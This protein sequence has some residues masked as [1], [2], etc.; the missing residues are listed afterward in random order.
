MT[1]PITFDL[2]GVI[3]I[4]IHVWNTTPPAIPVSPHRATPSRT[5][6]TAPTSRSPRS[7]LSLG[8]GCPLGKNCSLNVF[9]S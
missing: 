9:P 1:T 3:S 6:C 2:Q 4:Y 5:Y 7:L 8:C